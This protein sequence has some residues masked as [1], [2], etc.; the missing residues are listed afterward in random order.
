MGQWS[1]KLWSRTFRGAMD[2][3][4]KEAVNEAVEEAIGEAVGLG[5]CRLSL[6]ADLV[7]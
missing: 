1:E 5:L 3:A 4:V 7:K 6:I 2:E